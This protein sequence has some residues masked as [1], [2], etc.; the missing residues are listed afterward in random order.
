MILESSSTIINMLE[1]HLNKI[2]LTVLQHSISLDYILEKAEELC[3]V[4][5]SLLRSIVTLFSLL[6]TQSLSKLV[7][8]L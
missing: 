7:N 4:L 2:Y 1:K 5:K 6:S 8:A 3:C